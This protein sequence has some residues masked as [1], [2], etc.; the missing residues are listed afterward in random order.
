MAHERSPESA[1]KDT[2]RKTYRISP[3]RQAILPALFLMFVAALLIG[4]WLD[5]DPAS[6]RALCLT[7]GTVFLIGLPFFF[8]VRYT[9]LTISPDGVEVRQF[10]WT[11]G[12]AWDNVAALCLDPGAQGLELRRPM[13]GWGAKILAGGNAMVSRMVMFYPPEHKKLVDEHRWIP[14]EPFG[15]WFRHG[16]LRQDI[17]RHAPWLFEEKP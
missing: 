2:S 13:T 12:A 3:I 8:I 10:G 4:A 7:A 17:A 9:R 6:R 16:Q 11:V 5:K 14:V 1:A 15:W